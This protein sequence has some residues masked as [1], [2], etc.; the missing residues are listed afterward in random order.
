MC[1][2]IVYV[3]MCVYRMYNYVEEMN[4]VKYENFECATMLQY[5]GIQMGVELD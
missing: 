5:I 2:D 3:C 4:D 1:E